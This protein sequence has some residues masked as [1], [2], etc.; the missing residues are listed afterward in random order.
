MRAKGHEHRQEGEGA[1]VGQ[2]AERARLQTHVV[3]PGQGEREQVGGGGAHAGGEGEDPGRCERQHP[4]AAHRLG[5]HPAR[6]DRLVGPA[7]GAVEVAVQP[8]VAPA[9][10]QLAGEHRRPGPGRAPA[11]AGRDG[12]HGRHLQDGADCSP[13]AGVV[14]LAVQIRRLLRQEIVQSQVRELDERDRAR[15]RQPRAEGSCAEFLDVDRDDGDLEVFPVLLVLAP[16][17]ELGIEVTVAPLVGDADGAHLLLAHHR[18]VLGRG[19]VP[20]RRLLV[21]EGLL[22]AR[23]IWRADVSGLAAVRRLMG[24]SKLSFATA[25]ETKALTGMMIGGVTVLALPPDLPIYV[26]DRLTA[27]DWVVLGGGS[28]SWKVK[29]TPEIFRCLPGATIVSGLGLDA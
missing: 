15:A 14:V 17:H 13:E 24:V 3:G 23:A 29:T 4:S 21:A 27:L 10:R 5:G 18:L 26:D 28:R 19:D 6:G 1:G 12:Q 2:R 7:G 25:E 11:S 16:P 8:V 9:D 20:P 22:Y